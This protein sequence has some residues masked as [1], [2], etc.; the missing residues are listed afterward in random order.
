MNDKN[1]GSEDCRK[2]TRT[3]N[4]WF[5]KVLCE[6]GTTARGRGDNAVCSK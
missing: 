6:V 4:G 3:S 1:A 5:I 2:D